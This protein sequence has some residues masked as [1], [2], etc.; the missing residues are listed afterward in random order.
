MSPSGTMSHP[1]GGDFN[2]SV[3]SLETVCKTILGRAFFSS[4]VSGFSSGVSGLSS[5]VLGCRYGV[6]GF[7][8]LALGSRA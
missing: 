5:G 6:L 7:G 1:P 3:H 4:E 2:T 8:A